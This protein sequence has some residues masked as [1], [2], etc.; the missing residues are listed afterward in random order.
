[1]KSLKPVNSHKN[2]GDNP[3]GKVDPVTVLHLPPESDSSLVGMHNVIN[4]QALQLT[5]GRFFKSGLYN[6]EK[7][8]PHGLYMTPHPALEGFLL[9]VWRVHLRLN[10]PMSST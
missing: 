2:P 5:K 6:G 9:L 3:G 4:P 10:T 1:M 7:G 8:M